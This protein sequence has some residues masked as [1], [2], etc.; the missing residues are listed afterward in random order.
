M[1]GGLAEDMV[2]G[3]TV[4]MGEAVDGPKEPAYLG[5]TGIY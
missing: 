3:G 2:L 5:C 4:I 1:L